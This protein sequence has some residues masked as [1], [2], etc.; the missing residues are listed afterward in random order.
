M[1]AGGH[2][3]RCIFPGYRPSSPSSS[4]LNN[5]ATAI[6]DL[7][8]TLRSPVQTAMIGCKRKLAHQAIYWDYG[9]YVQ[10]NIFPVT[11]KLRY[12][13]DSCLR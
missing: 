2:L 3:S 4:P 5:L 12:W 1:Y 11:W 10:M 9:N 6:N 13:P 8:A 7:N